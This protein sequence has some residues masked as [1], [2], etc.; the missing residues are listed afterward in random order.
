MPVQTPGETPVD[1]RPGTITT[2]ASTFLIT[3]DP[4]KPVQNKVLPLRL[5]VAAIRFTITSWLMNGL[6]PNSGSPDK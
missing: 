6:P 5:V 1:P 2:P 4:G 3:S